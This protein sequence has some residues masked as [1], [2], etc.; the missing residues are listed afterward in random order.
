MVESDSWCDGSSDRFVMVNPFS[1]FTFQ[2]VFRNWCIY[3]GRGECYL[4]CVIGHIKDP[5]LLIKKSTLC[6]DCS[7]FSLSLSQRSFTIIYYV[8]CHII[9]NK[10]CSV[11][12]FLFLFIFC[13]FLFFVCF[14]GLFFGC[15]CLFW[16]GFFVGGF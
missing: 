2:P 14:F 5:L 3:K 12:L 10:M 4:V 13:L 6:S 7:G 1:Y 11:C 8:R 16:V 9:I 15:F